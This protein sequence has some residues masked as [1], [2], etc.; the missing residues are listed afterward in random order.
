MK[1][2]IDGPQRR[3]TFIQRICTVERVFANIRHNK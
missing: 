3:R 1:R 2:A